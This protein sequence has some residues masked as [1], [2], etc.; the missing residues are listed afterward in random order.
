M[1]SFDHT[2]NV[3]ERT[4]NSVMHHE[5]EDFRFE[6]IIGALLHDIGKTRSNDKI[7][8]GH[9]NKGQHHGHDSEQNHD[10]IDIFNTKCQLPK[11]TTKIAKVILSE[12]MRAK[13]GMKKKKILDLI[14]KL[15]RNDCI[16]Q[17]I[18]VCVADS[19]CRTNPN[20]DDISELNSLKQKYNTVMSVTS[21]DLD[22][23][24]QSY[25]NQPSLIGIDL[26]R[27]RA[28]KI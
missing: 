23:S 15:H 6:C 19:Q 18:T 26:R 3:L 16:D 25:V 13:S 8:K 11:K 2:M 20:P 12:H 1:S 24:K 7:E 9:M 22:M 5:N 10:L 14:L 4:A 21:K 17:F 27:L 28:S